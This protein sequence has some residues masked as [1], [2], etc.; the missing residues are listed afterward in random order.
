VQ[1][2]HLLLVPPPQMQ[3]Q[4]QGQHHP[5]LQGNTTRDGSKQKQKNQSEVTTNMTQST[6]SHGNPA[7]SLVML[8]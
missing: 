2:C 3:A 8:L 6:Q 7:T 1:H 5:R 4:L